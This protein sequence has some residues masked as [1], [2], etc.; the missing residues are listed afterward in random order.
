MSWQARLQTR[1]SMAALLL[2]S[3]ACVPASATA[4]EIRFAGPAGWR[5]MCTATPEFCNTTVRRPAPVLDNAAL[6]TLE[7]VNRSVNAAIVPMLDADDADTWRLAP[8]A[9]DCEDYALTKK[10]HLIALGWPARDLRFATLFTADGE[11][12]AVLFVDH[13]EGRMVLDNLADELRSW[14]AV[15]A[16][17]YRLVA[18]EGEGVDGGWRLTPYGSVVA[19]LARHAPAATP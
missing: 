18:V 10:Q 7:A 15:E 14:Q 6:A 19:M 2:L 5:A 12:H 11:Y 17:G 1:C 8:T 13:A 4:E 16:E 3:L 9:G